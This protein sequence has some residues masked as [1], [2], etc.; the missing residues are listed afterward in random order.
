MRKFFIAIALTAT[1][2]AIIV[3]A[4]FPELISF[5][6]RLFVSAKDSCSICHT[7]TTD[8]QGKKPPAPAGIPARSTY[9]ESFSNGE[10]QLDWSAFPGFSPDEMQAV[11]RGDTPENDGSAGRV[12]NESL[13]GF[14]SLSYAGHPELSDYSIEAWVYVIVTP[15]EQ[16]SLHGLAIRVD[17]EEQR[18]YRFA[19]QFGSERKLTIAYVGSDTNNFPVFIK[20]WDE[21]DIPGGAPKSSGWHKMKIRAIGNN[22]WAYWDDRELPDC[23]V[24]DD[25][26]RAGYFGVYTNFTGGTNVTQTLVDQIIVRQEAREAGASSSR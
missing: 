14:A 20:E 21:N 15:S 16:G 13:G 25:R 6:S 8:R 1:F 9:K 5:A 22:F 11:S 23:P 12:T 7:K 24:S 4:F 19:T 18:F 3:A 17:P 26:I 10:P 2:T